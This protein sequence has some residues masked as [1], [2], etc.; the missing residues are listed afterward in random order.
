MPLNHCQ[1]A[2][3]LE[4]SAKMANS[5]SS[6]KCATGNS[7]PHWYLNGNADRHQKET[8]ETVRKGL[9]LFN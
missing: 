8:V 4:I 5:I 1:I 2:R 6:Q 3:G 7:G 9:R